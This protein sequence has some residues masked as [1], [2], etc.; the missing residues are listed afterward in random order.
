MISVSL[1]LKRTGKSQIEDCL[2][3][4]SVNEILRILQTCPARSTIITGKYVLGDSMEISSAQKV[5]EGYVMSCNGSRKKRRLRKSERTRQRQEM[6]C[7]KGSRI[8]PD[9]FPLD[10]QKKE[11]L[12]RQII[13][14]T[15]RISIVKK[16]SWENDESGDSEAQTIAESWMIYFGIEACDS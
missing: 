4:P 15:K 16:Y 9:V 3:R 1:V 12:N 10:V 5:F 7:R 2:Q 14:S 13:L 11:T 8:L 6:L